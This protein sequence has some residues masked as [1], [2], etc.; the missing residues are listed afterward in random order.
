MEPPDIPGKKGMVAVD[1]FIDTNGWEMS[2]SPVAFAF[3]LSRSAS[4]KGLPW[5][6]LANREYP[7]LTC[8][9]VLY[10]VL[11]GWH[12]DVTGV[13]YNPKTNAFA[14]GVIGFKPLANHW[15][16]WTFAELGDSVKL[17]QRYEGQK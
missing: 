2:S 5:K 6:K 14:P 3:G 12:H 16:V 15:Y 13:A 8:G 7:A 11:D 1:A 4:L 17:T 10:V 9:G